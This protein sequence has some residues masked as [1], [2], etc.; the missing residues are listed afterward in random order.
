MDLEIIK[1]NKSYL[2]SD[3]DIRVQDIRVSS[4]PLI[5]NR[6]EIDGFPGSLDYGSYYGDRPITVDFYIKAR[7]DHDYSHLRDL[8]FELLVDTRPYYIRD[9]RTTGEY[10]DDSYC[11]QKKVESYVNGKQYHVA[12]NNTIDLDQV[13]KVGFGTIEYLT[14][15]LPFAESIYTTKELND[16]DYDALVEKY[17]LVDGINSDNTKYKFTERNFTI[18]NAGNV[19]VEPET[20]YL[21]ITATGTNGVLEIRNKTTG[22]VFKVNAEFGGD[23]VIDGINAQLKST[24]VFRDTNRRYIRLESGKNEFEVIGQFTDIT[25]DFRFYYK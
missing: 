9:V 24:N 10:E 17:G 8:L 21:K 22:D 5:T 25:I 4:I 7:D 12:V 11:K 19:T 1:D 3:F 6:Q 14:S 13:M 23:L 2:L 20:M 16:T 18:W 15:D